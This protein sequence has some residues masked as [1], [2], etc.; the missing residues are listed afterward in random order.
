MRRIPRD[1]WTANPDNWGVPGS[2]RNPVSKDREQL[3]KIPDTNSWLLQADAH[4]YKHTQVDTP[5]ASQV[6]EFLQIVFQKH[7]LMLALFP[8]SKETGKVMGRNIT[9]GSCPYLLASKLQ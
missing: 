8:S 5:K 1:D 3:R 4:L 6:T 9:T 7:K 2:E